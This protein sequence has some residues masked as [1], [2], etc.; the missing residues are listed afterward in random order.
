MI[1]QP[2][3]LLGEELSL[4]EIKQALTQTILEFEDAIDPFSQSILVT[5]T[6]LAQAGKNAQLSQSLPIEVT[7][8]LDAMIAVMDQTRQGGGGLVNGPVAG[9]QS[10][11]NGQGGGDI[12]TD[13]VA[14]VS[15]VAFDSRGPGE[16][17]HGCTTRQLVE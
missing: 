10:A 12:K 8:V 11:F 4:L 15:I 1:I 2:D 13:D 5:I 17:F 14:G 16:D 7:G 6:H 3:S 9:P